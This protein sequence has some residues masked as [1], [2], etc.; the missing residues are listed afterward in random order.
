MSRRSL[1]CRIVVAGGG[2]IGAAA[3]LM[4]ARAGATVVLADGG[5][6]AANASGVAAGMLAPVFEAILDPLSPAPDLLAEARDL[7]SPLAAS[8]GLALDRGGAM[9]IGTPLE[10]ESWAGAAVALGLTTRDLGPAEV[11]AR[12]PWLAG[13]YRGLWTP[14]DWRLSPAD[15][16][17]TLR[18]A[19]EAL[20]VEWLAADLRHFE[21]GVASLGDGRRIACD[22]LVVATGAAASPRDL[23]PELASLT[24]VKGHIL[25]AP[26]LILS[27]PVVRLNG[28]YLCPTPGGAMIG[29]TMEPG[30]TDL[31]ID[32]AAVA[33][34]RALAGR[35]APAALSAPV[36]A[37]AGIRAATPDGLPLV[38]ASR[39]PGVW[40]SAGARRNGWLLAPLIARL[41]VDQLSGAPSGA[42]ADAMRPRRFCPPS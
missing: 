34:L 35:I 24:P 9:A 2:A 15:A 5:P 16:L 33:S 31:E 10:L 7:W 1:A 3:A 8:I 26:S 40:I 36:E 20:G 32:P 29:A 4:L 22:V 17:A 39:T 38:G 11:R 41:L 21:P 14:D 6:L 18:A 37:R 19:S 12:S 13:D 25:L 28:G 27:G 42:W 30:R 23:A